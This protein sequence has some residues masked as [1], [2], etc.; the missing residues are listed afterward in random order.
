MLYPNRTATYNER[1]INMPKTVDKSIILE[2]IGE[3]TSVRLASGEYLNV[4]FKRSSL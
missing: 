1:F 2:N 3:Y 4:K